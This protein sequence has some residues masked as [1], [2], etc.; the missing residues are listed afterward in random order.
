VHG[1]GVPLLD[2]HQQIGIGNALSVVRAAWIEDRALIGTLQF[3]QAHEGRKAE[4][5]ISRGEPNGVSIG[6]CVNDWKSSDTEGNITDPKVDHLR[7][8]D[9]DLVFTASR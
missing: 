2:S 9:D 1:A 4:D 5:M 6:Y 7:W 3:N 8:S